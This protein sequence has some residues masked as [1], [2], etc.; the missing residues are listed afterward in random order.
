[1]PRRLVEVAVVAEKFCQAAGNLGQ[2]V[3]PAEKRE[4]V[5]RAF[6]DIF[7][8]NPAVARLRLDDIFPRKNDAQLL[9]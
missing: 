8:V 5:A 1:M 3:L 7:D 2:L 6:A 9:L 4:A